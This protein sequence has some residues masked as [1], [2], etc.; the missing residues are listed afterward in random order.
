MCDGLFV[1]PSAHEITIEQ[2]LFKVVPLLILIIR[3]GSDILLKAARRV[4]GGP[5]ITPCNCCDCGEATSR[6]TSPRRI[7]HPGWLA[8]PP[9]I[10]AIELANQKLFTGC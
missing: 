7:S 4:G 6:T 1:I 8:S 5:E 9:V 3:L 2:M 10:I